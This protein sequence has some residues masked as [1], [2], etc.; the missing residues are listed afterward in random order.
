MCQKTLQ[1]PPTFRLIFY[2]IVGPSSSVKAAC[3]QGCSSVSEVFEVLYLKSTPSC[4]SAV[5][6]RFTAALFPDSCF[7]SQS[8]AAFAQTSSHCRRNWVSD[9]SNVSPLPWL[10]PDRFIDCSSDVLSISFRPLTDGTQSENST[11]GHF[12]Q[13]SVDAEQST[14]FQWVGLA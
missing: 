11:S 1:R 12:D 13:E 10:G 2:S 7:S 9:K 14:T 5:D 8:H 4:V 6:L 3:L